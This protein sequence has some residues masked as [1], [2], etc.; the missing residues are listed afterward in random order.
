MLVEER[1]VG[2]KY[3]DKDHLGKLALLF[4]QILFY[5][6]LN[7]INLESHCAIL[8]RLDFKI[9]LYII[10]FYS[11]LSPSPT[12]FYLF[13]CLFFYCSYVLSVPHHLRHVLFYFLFFIISLRVFS[14]STSLCYRYH[15]YVP[16]IFYFKIVVDKVVVD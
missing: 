8:V 7:K 5:F 15:I 10:F 11:F 16:S 9:A 1:I 12:Y 14:F 13:V 3:N 2:F 6:C 4:A